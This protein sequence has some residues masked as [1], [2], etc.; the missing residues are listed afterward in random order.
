VRTVARV[1]GN[2]KEIVAGLRRVGA[3]VQHIHTVGH[4]CP[5]IAVG[6][7]GVNYLLEIKTATGTLT[8]DEALWHA[9]WRGQV[10]VVRSLDDALRVI[11]C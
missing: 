7:R 5:D 1:D 9:T 4:G 6:F 10:D 8:D 11:G 3:D 2:Q